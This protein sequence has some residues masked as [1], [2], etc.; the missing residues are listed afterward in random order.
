M[1]TSQCNTLIH[2]VSILNITRY[3]TQVNRHSINNLIDAVHTTIQ[4]INNLYNL[5]TSL[6]TSINFNQMLLHI[7]LVFANL[8]PLV[9]C[10]HMSY[11]SWIYKRCSDTLLTPYLQPYTYQFHQRTLYISAS[12]C[13]L[14][15]WLKTNSFYYWLTYPYKIEPARSQCTRSL[16]WIF[17]M[18]TIQLTMT[19]TPDA[20]ESPKMQQ[21]ELSS[22]LHNSRHVNKPMDSSATFQH[23]FSC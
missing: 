7:R 10:H 1:Q 5:T 3:T 9:Y 19:W 12:T 14:M 18:E 13:V 22:P 4:D 8:P 2:I 20:L 15:S 21:W 23:L 6:A 16:L 11:P 17:P